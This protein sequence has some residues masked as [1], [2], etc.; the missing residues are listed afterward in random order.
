MK[1]LSELA[2]DA[3]RTV[4]SGFYKTSFKH[5]P[6]RGGL[7][8]AIKKRKGKSIISEVKFAS[9]SAGKIRGSGDPTKIAKE[10]EAGG[11]VGLSVLTDPKNFHGS[12][13]NFIAV[14]RETE[15]PIIMKDI[16]VSSVQ[17][18]TARQIG[19]DAVLFIEEIFSEGLAEQG[20][21]LNEAVNLAKQKGL[22]TIVET[23]TI[24]GMKK[25]DM[26]GCD[27]LGIN[28]RDLH[29]FETSTDTTA[30]VL[31]YRARFPNRLVMSESGFESP[32][33][34]ITLNEK[35]R[36]DGIFVPDAFLIG[37]AIMRAVNIRDTVKG[38]V[39]ALN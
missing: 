4:D 24:D 32:Q 36:S 39:E 1:T 30:R 20:L 7:V 27:I 35:L 33:D 26:S 2:H 29:T 21:S 18:N 12:I 14:R 8:Q 31:R 16:I 34:I 9:P 38:F 25:A 17:V 13:S 28:N 11:S 22:D 3:K 10:M 6:K 37:T 23:H 19:A 5:E 15:L